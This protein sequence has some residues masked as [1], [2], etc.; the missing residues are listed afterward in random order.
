[1]SRQ[2]KL[3]KQREYRIWTNMKN[4][5]FNPNNPAYRLAAKELHGEFARLNEVEESHGA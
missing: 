3:K 4:R 5:C 2:S 1:M